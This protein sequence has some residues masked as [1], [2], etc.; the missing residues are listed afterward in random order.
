VPL[1][2]LLPRRKDVLRRWDVQRGHN[3]W[4]SLGFHFDHTDPSLTL[5]LPFVILAMGR[6]K[7]P[8]FRP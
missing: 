6:L 7:Q 2:A 3:P 4:L 1:S 8:G 5:H